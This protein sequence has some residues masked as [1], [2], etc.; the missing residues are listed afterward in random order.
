[1]GADDRRIDKEVAGQGARP[2]LEMFPEPTPDAAPFP[3]AKAVIHR[4]PLAK[5]LGQVAPWRPCPGE[6]E[7]GLDKEPIAE[8]RW[9]AG[10]GFEGS[11]DGGQ[12]GPRLV[13][14][15]QTYRHHISSSSVV[16]EET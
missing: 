3:A 1:M 10:A 16:L 6:I 15:Q 7:H 13:R 12:L 2:G 11:E 8:H 9:A 5:V 14:E 4:V